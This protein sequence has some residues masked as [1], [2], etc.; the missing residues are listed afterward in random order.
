MRGNRGKDT[1][2]EIR[3]RKVLHALGLR[4]RVS[5]R[6]LSNLRRTVD[7]AFPGPR[8]A[9]FVDGCYWH[10]CPDHY[11]PATTNAEFWR[12]KIETNQE[13]DLETTRRLEDA[14]WRVLR[15]WEHEDPESAACR[16][17]SLVR[18]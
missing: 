18:E 2:P 16:V 3:L 17:F 9:V 14:G 10:G 12:K 4:Y 6:P 13:R 7:V 11:R 1:K 5:I 15:F 8:V